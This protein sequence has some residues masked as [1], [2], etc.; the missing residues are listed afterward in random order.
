MQNIMYEGKEKRMALIDELLKVAKIQDLPEEESEAILIAMHQEKVKDA[1][2]EALQGE[3]VSKTMDGL[4]KELLRFQQERKIQKTVKMADEDRR[5][6][7]FIES[8]KRQAELILRQREQV[9]YD[10]VM[11]LHHSTVDNYMTH[12]ISSTIRDTS[13]RQASIMTNLRKE[14]I[15]AP[16]E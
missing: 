7:E 16:I 5:K 8:G 15:K 11:Q 12:M 2:M 13:H 6:R 10:E 9:L 4:S 14:K 1:L 3:V